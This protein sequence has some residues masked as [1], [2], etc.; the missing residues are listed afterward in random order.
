MRQRV[1]MTEMCQAA[2]NAPSLDLN[3][4]SYKHEINL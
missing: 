3:F 1:E 2:P 4:F